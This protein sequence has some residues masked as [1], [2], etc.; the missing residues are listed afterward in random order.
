MELKKGNKQ[1]AKCEEILYKED[2]GIA[3][4]FLYTCSLV[5]IYV[6]I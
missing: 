6:M 5:D 2:H 4:I 1:C 3:Y